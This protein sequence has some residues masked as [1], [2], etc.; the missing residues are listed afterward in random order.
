MPGPDRRLK[1]AVELFAGRRLSAAAELAG[2]LWDECDPS[3]DLASLSLLAG[4]LPEAESAIRLA[5]ADLSEHPRL[6][7]LLAETLR[8]LA[9]RTPVAHPTRPPADSR[10]PWPHPRNTS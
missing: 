5:L 4:R 6:R 1:T 7:A 10:A 2:A 3:L 8:R 9:P